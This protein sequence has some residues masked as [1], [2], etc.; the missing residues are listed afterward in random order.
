[1]ICLMDGSNPSPKAKGIWC[2]VV[3][4]HY[5]GFSGKPEMVHVLTENIQ[6]TLQMLSTNYVMFSVAGPFADRSGQR[7]G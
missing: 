3:L 6:M 4:G 1:M 5:A 2:F 7:K